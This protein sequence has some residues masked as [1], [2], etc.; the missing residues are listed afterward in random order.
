MN[1]LQDSNSPRLSPASGAKEPGKTPGSRRKSLL[2]SASRVT[3]FALGL[4]TELALQLVIPNLST[5][6]SKCLPQAKRSSLTADE[7]H[8]QRRFAT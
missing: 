3:Y 4:N 7:P 8:S 1:V 5:E 2:G 6:A